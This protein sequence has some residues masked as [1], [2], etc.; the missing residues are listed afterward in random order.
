LTAD[1]LRD[2]DATISR[3]PVTGIRMN[4]EQMKVVETSAGG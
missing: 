3:N 1:D 2:L 4:E